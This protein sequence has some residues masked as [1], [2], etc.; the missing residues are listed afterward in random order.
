MTSYEL[1]NIGEESLILLRTNNCGMWSEMVEKMFPDNSVVISRIILSIRVAEV[2]ETHEGDVQ[3][4]A[5]TNLV[6]QKHWIHHYQ[7]LEDLC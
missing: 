2:A 1:F 4:D 6:D 3:C 7:I 5:K